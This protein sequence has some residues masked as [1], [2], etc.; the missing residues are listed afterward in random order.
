MRYE[1]NLCSVSAG[2]LIRPLRCA[3]ILPLLHTP[4]NDACLANTL[5][6]IRTVH[7]WPLLGHGIRETSLSTTHVRLHWLD[8]IR[9]TKSMSGQNDQLVKIKPSFVPFTWKAFLVVLLGL[10]L[11]VGIFLFQSLLPI[12]LFGF[13]YLLRFLFLGLAGLDLLTILIMSRVR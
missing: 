2:L 11:Y 3:T 9:V 8:Y 1:R 7:V 4:H 10:T 5:R 6:P 13:G 12:P